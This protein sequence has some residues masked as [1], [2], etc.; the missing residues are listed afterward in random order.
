MNITIIAVGKLKENYWISAISEYQK[1]LRR[2]CRLN[3]VEIPDEGVKAGVPKSEIILARK[4]EGKKIIEKIPSGSYVTTLEINGKMCD[5]ISFADKISSLTI[6]G[7]SNLT[8]IIGG[9]YGLDQSVIALSQ[10]HLSFSPMTFPHQLFRVI[11]LEQVYRSF[12]IINHETY[13]K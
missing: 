13:H 8:F 7:I 11:L 2:F 1:R 12:K 6:N 9:S 10:W 3:I 5:S 4:K